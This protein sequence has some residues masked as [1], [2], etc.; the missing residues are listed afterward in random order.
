MIQRK[1]SNGMPKVLFIQ[2]NFYY[3]AFFLKAIG[4]LSLFLLPIIFYS[5]HLHSPQRCMW[6]RL[7]LLSQQ[8]D[9]IPCKPVF[10][11]SSQRDVKI[12]LQPFGVSYAGASYK[13]TVLDTS[14]R[15]SAAQGTHI[16]TLQIFALIQPPDSSWSIASNRLSFPHG[17]LLLL[18]ARTNK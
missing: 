1:G 16:S 6:E 15:R 2:N 8:D 3:D 4:W 14:G 5:R 9:Q 11:H 12:F 13:Y 17:T 7:V 18:R 10:V